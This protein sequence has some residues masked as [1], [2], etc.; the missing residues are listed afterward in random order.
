MTRDN[1]FRSHWVAVANAPQARRLG[2]QLRFRAA[3]RACAG[4]E[5]QPTCEERHILREH[6]SLGS[7][8]IGPLSTA[9]GLGATMGHVSSHV[10]FKSGRTRRGDLGTA[11]AIGRRSNNLL[12]WILFGVAAAV[13]V[14][15]ATEIGLAL[16]LLL[17]WAG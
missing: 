1:T 3:R 5:K 11:L 7:K 9:R 12:D 13:I 14:I 2:M 6:R 8:N 16:R 10:T 15:A 4:R 17:H